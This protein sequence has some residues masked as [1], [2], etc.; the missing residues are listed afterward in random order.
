M[1][2]GKLGGNDLNF[3]SD[4]DLI[5]YY[6]PENLP[7]SANKGQKYVINKVLQRLTRILK[8]NH[9]AEFVWRVDWRLRPESSAGGLAMTVDEATSFYFFRALPWHRLA[10]MKARVVAGDTETGNAFLKDLT[11]FIWRQNL[12]FRALDELAH[13]KSRIN[14][15]HPGLR[16]ERAQ[17]KPITP[18]AAGFNV[19]LGSGG[20]REIEFIANAQQ[21]VWGGKQYELRTTNTL[22]A[23]AALTELG[24]ISQTD[25][26]MLKDNYISLRRLENAIQMLWNEQTHTVPDSSDL[27]MDIASLLGHDWKHISENLYRQRQDVNAV[28]TQLFKSENTNTDGAPNIDT[29]SDGGQ[30][31]AQSWLS[32]FN[33][34][35]VGQAKLTNFQKLG[36]SLLVRVMNSTADPDMSLSRIDAFLKSISRSEQYLHLL[37]RNPK[38]LD[39]LIT[40]LLHSPHMTLLLE[41]SPHII[42]VFLN[43]QN[44]MTA[45]DTAPNTDF[46]FADTDYETRLERLRRFVN[47]HLFQYYHSFMQESEGLSQLQ[48][49]LTRL[50]ETTLEAAIEIVRCDLNLDELPISVLGL[51]KMGTQRMAPQSD[52]DLIFVFDDALEAETSAKVVRRLRTAIT[53]PLREGIAYELDMRLRPSGRSGPPAVKLASLRDH[54]MTRAKTWEHIALAHSKVIAGDKGL[55][56][57]VTSARDAILERPREREQFLM[58]AKLMWSRIAEQRIRDTK[59]DVINAKLRTGGLMQ[60]EY[61]DACI[62]VLGQPSDDL[63]PAITF[64]SEMQIWERL[65]GLTDHPI[66]DIPER[67][68][69]S[70]LG[71]KPAAYTKAVKAYEKMVINRMDKLFGHIKLPP[72][73][74]EQP[75]RWIM[76]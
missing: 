4:V 23:L 16:Q 44:T 14:L 39:A 7:I 33:Q 60:A 13:L 61:L 71:P 45:E 41:Q 73:Y 36:T 62:K 56:I 12:D 55:G 53:T 43:P 32:G 52:L 66:N 25:S 48:K 22:Q 40:P 58:D 46:I 29:L 31:I 68:K 18:N 65:L 10:L 11:P 28:F 49:N 3:S 2:L 21:L 63:A 15:E 67:F 34:H 6:D 38:L 5:A 57:N 19:K 47:E 75:I 69:S 8:P 42:D 30:P 27:Q 24:H 1:G 70:V 37:Q 26:E 76:T 72:R 54:H 20:I 64:W 9:S 59:S 17:E 35:G 51:G 50:A 74:S